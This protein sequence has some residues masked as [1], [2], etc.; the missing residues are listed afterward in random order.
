MSL[1]RL[2]G[3]LLNVWWA[4]PSARTAASWFWA[5]LI[6][7]LQCS[8]LPDDILGL[9]WF[10]SYCLVGFQVYI[11]TATTWDASKL[12]LSSSSENNFVLPHQSHKCF[13]LSNK[14][15]LK[16]CSL[17]R[18]RAKIWS[19]SEDPFWNER[20]RKDP[21][22]P[23]LKWSAHCCCCLLLGHHLLVASWGGWNLSDMPP[24]NTCH[25]TFSNPAN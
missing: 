4:L 6:W 2:Y 3:Q 12:W 14:A 20:V 5:L 21:E 15:A 18:V 17:S 19:A 1:E 7:Y 8:S 9:G 25:S 10:H 11:Q 23:L 22:P 16:T 13:W 24:W